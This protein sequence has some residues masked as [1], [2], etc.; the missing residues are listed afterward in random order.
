MDIISLAEKMALEAHKNDRYG[1]KPYY[2]HLFEVKAQ[3]EKILE[4]PSMLFF[5]QP[6]ALAASM[7]HDSVE[8]TKLSVWTIESKL[9][10]GVGQLVY[11]VT[12]CQGINRAERKKKTYPKIRS[13]G[14][15]AV[16]LKLAD[17]IANVQ[18]GKRNNIGLV[19]MYE[20]EMS[21]FADAL[22]LYSDGLD[23]IW[24]KLDHLFKS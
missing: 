24:N 22:Y 9:G 7:L 5:S 18:E 1:D 17:R 19:R 8:D 2:E 16:A 20:K 14:P 4:L 11:S 21:A 10:K 15:L 6:I 12:D 23:S 3:M 13:N